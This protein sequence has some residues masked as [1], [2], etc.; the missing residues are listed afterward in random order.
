VSDTLTECQQGYNQ[1]I[2][3]QRNYGVVRKEKE[4]ETV[5]QRYVIMVQAVGKPVH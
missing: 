2:K 4:I 5:A 1:E 3:F